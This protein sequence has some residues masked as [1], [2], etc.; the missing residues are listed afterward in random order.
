MSQEVQ[1]QGIL[2]VKCPE[3]GTKIPD[4]EKNLWRSYLR[5][6]EIALKKKPMGA[7]PLLGSGER[8]D[9]FFTSMWDSLMGSISFLDRSNKAMSRGPVPPSEK[10]IPK[11]RNPGY[12]R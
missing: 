6:L 2:C 4:P 3:C 8:N 12:E 1:I 5:K 7:R 10:A 11:P 9:K